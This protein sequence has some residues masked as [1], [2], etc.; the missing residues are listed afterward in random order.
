MKTNSKSSND[1]CI[2]CWSI[3]NLLCCIWPLGLFALI[4][5]FKIREL[6]SRGDDQGA[7]RA[8]RS[9]LKLNKY[10]TIFG[11]IAIIILIILIAVSI[12]QKTR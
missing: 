1:C 2:L 6:R 7:Q 11:I 5:Y 12:K 8:E 3:F 10:S 9:A 4:K